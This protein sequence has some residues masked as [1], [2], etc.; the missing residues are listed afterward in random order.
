MSRWKTDGWKFAAAV[1]GVAIALVLCLA[2]GVLAQAPQN[3]FKPMTEVASET[4][5]ATPLVYIAYGFVW[6][7]LLAYVFMLWQRVGK[8]ERELADVNAR[9]RSPRR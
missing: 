4:L 9:L 1:L 6:V 8:V 5:P 7:A 2:P 3:E